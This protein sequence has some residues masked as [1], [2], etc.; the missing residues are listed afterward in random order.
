VA[1]AGP[2][3]GGHKQTA[4]LPDGNGPRSCLSY[5]AS[6]AL[7]P[8]RGTHKGQMSEFPTRSAFA[9]HRY[10]YPWRSIL[11]RPANAKPR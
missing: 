8:L 9:T 5:A 1:T 11:Y 2:W 3:L 6:A 4:P 10:A 7:D